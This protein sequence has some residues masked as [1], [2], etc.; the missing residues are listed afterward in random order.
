MLIARHIRTRHERR[1]CRGPA[2]VANARC[3]CLPFERCWRRT[4]KNDA[5]ELLKVTRWRDCASCSSLRASRPS[6]AAR[7]NLSASSRAPSKLT[8][9]QAPSPRSTL[10]P[11]IVRRRA[12]R[13]TPLS[14]TTR[15]NPPPSS[16]RPGNLSFETRTALKRFIART[17][18][19]RLQRSSIFILRHPVN[20]P[21]SWSLADVTGRVV[22]AQADT[23]GR[24][25][26]IIRCFQTGLRIQLSCGVMQ[27]Q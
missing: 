21:N 7:R 6:F 13:F 17:R 3:T 14:V 27:W 1:C 26:A 18:V 4:S 24:A 12:Q 20:H 9:G 11:R 19:T 25:S 8:N 10:R 16:Y 23:T 15:R 22:A 2:G 5:N